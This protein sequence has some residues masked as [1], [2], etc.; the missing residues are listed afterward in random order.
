M[1]ELDVKEMDKR[2]DLVQVCVQWWALFEPSGFASKRASC[3][4]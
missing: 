4:F 2:K 3:V 1:V